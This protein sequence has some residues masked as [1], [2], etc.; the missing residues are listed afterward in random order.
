M[1]EIPLMRRVLANNDALADEQLKLLEKNR[2]LSINIMS[3]PGA[4]KTSLIEK[5]IA[6]LKPQYR[7]WVIE[8]DIQ[9]DL[10]ARRVVACG[11]GCTQINTQGACHLDGMMLAR[12]FP[13]LPLGEIDLLIIENVGNLVCPAEFRLP[14]HYNITVVS[15]PEG[16]DK[17]AKYPLMFSKSDVLVVNKIDLLPY[18]D[19]NLNEF[20]RSVR[21]LKPQI[22][23]LTLSVRTGEGLENWIDWIKKAL[24]QSGRRSTKGLKG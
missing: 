2:V 14:A 15:T 7:I 24:R 4:G 10:D 16:S 20:T 9:G 6:V 11:V 13:D 17:P 22:P 1:A 8:G 5:T 21:K 18:V 3:G 23:I 19:F 12:V